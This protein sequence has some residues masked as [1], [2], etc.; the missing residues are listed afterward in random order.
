MSIAL[1][2]SKVRDLFF[3]CKSAF[4]E[5]L[6]P[7]GA[8]CLACG[9]ISDGESLCPA[10]RK[11]L[12]ETDLLESWEIRDLGGV[13]SW[14]MRPH[15]G[16]ARTLVLRLKHGAESRAA[17]ALATLYRDR[18]PIFPDLPKNMVVTWV[19]SP[20]IR[21]R[22]RCVD[23]GQVLARAIAKEAGLPCEELLRRR[24]NDRPQAQLRRMQ[25]EKN[26]QNA[27]EPACAIETPVLLVD[28]VMTTGTTAR[29]C[30]AALREGGAKEIIVLTATGS[31]K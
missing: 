5:V 29:R 28:D 3:R 22:E 16:L 14:S 18:P 30:I 13:S 26:L 20:K 4:R 9:K 31:I 2:G 25:R 8:V 27:F 1:T 10:C 12:M 24:G 17:E 15:R 23:H 19:P 11:K 6:Y 7:E 21:I